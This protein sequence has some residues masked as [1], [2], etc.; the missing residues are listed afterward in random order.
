M[1]LIPLKSFKAPR[2]SAAARVASLATVPS[3]IGGLNFA[4]PISNM[5]LSDALILTNWIPKRTGVDL[6]NGYQYITDPVG[7]DIGSIFPYNASDPANNKLFAAYGGSIWDITD[8][9]P[10]DEQVTDSTDNRWNTTQFANGAGLFLLAVSPTGG[11]WTY[12]GTSWTEQTVT[13][14]PANPTSIAVWKNRV[15]FTVEASSTVYYLDTV[16]AITGTAVGFEMGSL[17]RNGGYVRGLINWT[18]D[19]G[20]SLDDM[21]T[22][23]GSEG[24][25]GVW[26]GTDP[27]SASTFGLKGVWYVGPVPRY[28]RFF[29]AYGGD[30]MIVSELGMVPLSRLVSGQFSELTPGPSFKVQAV[31]SPLIRT[32]RNVPSWDVFIVPSSDVLV[33]KLPANHNTY[34]QYAMNVNTGAWCTFSGLNMECSCLLNGQLYFATDDQRVCKGLFGEYDAV[35]IEGGLGSPIDGEI[36]TAFNAFDAPGRLK[37]FSMARPIFIARIAPSF[38]TR[39]NT[40]YSFSAPVGAPA[41]FDGTSSFWDDAQWD[42]ARWSAGSRTFEKWVG[43]NG[44]GYYGALRM[45]TRALGGTSF[46]SFHVMT[47]AGGF[48]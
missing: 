15:W 4:D 36:Q 34:T 29:T 8:G 11:Y 12:D 35:P 6:R 32:L 48:M 13:G 26:Q 40:Q 28:G 37:K 1:P 31:L 30:V 43:V 24:D 10:T 17:L 16:D 39:I 27:T 9:T 22:V 2:Q 38:M 33:I 45:R 46:A 42:L 3:P 5:P 18:V 7:D 47:T 23:V 44:L 19:S 25:I 20:F 21:L 14:L 41:F